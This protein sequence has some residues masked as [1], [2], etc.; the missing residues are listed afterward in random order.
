MDPPESRQVTQAIHAWRVD[1]HA[2]KGH[3]LKIG[4]GPVDEP[5]VIAPLEEIRVLWWTAVS[6]E[7]MAV[8]SF[9]GTVY[10]V[11][12]DDVEQRTKRVFTSQR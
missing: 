1:R 6:G 12:E 5:I 11:R 9:L 3:L 8:V 10:L 7:T 4:I 2:S